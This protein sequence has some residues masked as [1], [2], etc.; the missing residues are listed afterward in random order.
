[1][2]HLLHVNKKA[3]SE[4]VGYTLL[5]IIAL[6][7]SVM[8]YSFLKVYLPK[9]TAQCEEDITLIVQEA[10]CSYSP[11]P[12]GSELNITLINKGL[13]KVDSAYIR[14]GNLT[15]K[16]KTQINKN[17][18]EL[19]GQSGINNVVGLN[20]GEKFSTTYNATSAVPRAGSYV[21]EIQPAVYQGRRIV[22]CDR[23]IITQPIECK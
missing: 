14:L 17:H 7:L 8:V 3:V 6:G 21:L 2:K 16:V 15:Q 10:A 18:T 5:I 20:P 13:F 11:S 4:V 12:T 19:Y 23:A 22:L 9:E 1:M